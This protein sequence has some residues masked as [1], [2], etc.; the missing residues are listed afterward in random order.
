M[1]FVYSL[2]YKDTI[3]ANKILY[4][5]NIFIKLS[6]FETNLN[7]IYFKELFFILQIGNIYIHIFYINMDSVY[8]FKI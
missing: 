5:K 7:E 4:A 3:L 1:F 6:K 2:I 8:V